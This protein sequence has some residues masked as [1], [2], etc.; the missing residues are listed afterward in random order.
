MTLPGLNTTELDGALGSI[1]SGAKILAVAGVCSSGTP[2]APAGYG[3]KRALYADFGVGP[4]VEM[5]SRAIDAGCVVLICRTGQ[6]TDGAMGTIDDAAVTGT[7]KTFITHTSGTKPLDDYQVKVLVTTGGTTG[8][9]GIVYQ[10]SLDGGR[11]YGPKTALGTA[12]TIAPSTT[13]VSFDI[14]TGKT[15]VAGD[16]WTVTTTAPAPN[17][18]EVTSAL[19]ALQNSAT[20]WGVA[21]LAFP[22]D[23]T[24][25]DVV[26]TAFA[27]MST[28]GKPR[29]YVGGFRI[30]TDTETE[31]TYKTAFETALSAKATTYG[32]ICAGAVQLVSSLQGGYIKG[33]SFRRPV[34][35][36]VAP[37]TAAVEE[38]IDIA[39]VNLG[40]AT[41]AAL[42]DT[43]GN[44]AYHDESINPGLDDDRACT[45]RTWDGD[46]QG[47]YVTRP[48]IF[49]A[50]GSDFSIMPLRR[51][52]NLARIAIRGY[53]IRRLNRPVQ[54]DKR[55]GY[56]LEAEAQ[57]IEAGGNAILKAALGGTPKASAWSFT[58]RRDDNLLSTKTMNTETRIV[59]L[60]YPE[61]INNAIG[62]E[63]PALVA[64][65]A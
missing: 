8:T 56:I 31:S 32:S 25:F 55:T 51:V 33:S 45:L 39:D 58:V 47:V 5:A 52:M 50:N 1:P 57:E 59:P 54:V 13:G 36:H 41:G 46:V 7:A 37:A 11:T 43:N 3:N 18:S 21:G 30:P 10:V 29:A 62:F 40:P 34:C 64:I 38:H 48:R 65:A 35:F 12:L 28:A 17:A 23:G 49:C 22:I 16:Y 26:E 27:A 2:N 60:A 6:T 14:T 24:I 4:A 9:A 61:T 42:A 20:Q 63:N 19:T 53:L 15:L 44:N